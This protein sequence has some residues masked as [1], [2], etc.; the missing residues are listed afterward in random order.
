MLWEKAQWQGG[1]RDMKT[2]KLKDRWLAAFL[3]VIVVMS[4][5]FFASFILTLQA[6]EKDADRNH[7]KSAVFMK[8]MLDESWQRVFDYSWQIINAP[9]AKRMEREDLTELLPL[10]YEFS[11]DF[12]NYIQSNKI[13]ED[14]Y[15]YY[16]ENGIVI[17]NRG[18]YN[19]HV[20]WVTLYGI[21]KRISE[22]SWNAELLENRARGYFTIQ[23]GTQLELYYRMAS[24]KDEGRILIAKI[25][26]EELETTLRW[27]CDDNA[28]SFLAMS[29]EDGKIYAY[30][31]SYERF[32]DAETNTVSS[33]L[34]D[35]YLITEKSSDITKLV[36]LTVTEK[37]QAYR[38]MTVI[39]RIS[40]I[41]LI[42]A[43]TV[44]VLIAVA[45]TSRSVKPVEK[46]VEKLRTD[47]APEGNEISFIEQQI[48]TLLTESRQSV[49][50]LEKQREM[51]VRRTFLSE[52]LKM[53]SV[54]QRDIEVIAGFYGQEFDNERYVIIVRERAGEDYSDKILRY[55]SEFEETPA[56]LCWT[57]QQDLDVFFLNYDLVARNGQD[58]LADFLSDLK[59]RSSPASRI[60]CS[61]SVEY[62]EQI[63]NCYLECLQQ[64]GRVESTLLPGKA[65]L[66]SQEQGFQ[67]G[68]FQ[69]YIYDEDY[70]SARAMVPQ[71]CRLLFEDTPDQTNYIGRK[72]YLLT[73]L[74]IKNDPS[75]MKCSSDFLTRRIQPLWRTGCMRS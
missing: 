59:E 36:Y 10:A 4:T 26:T 57:Q 33:K 38:L 8:K 44:S 30:A 40:L 5:V 53:G 17:G 37:S 45:F 64:L 61:Q 43:I 69:S 34:E 46:I 74:K 23:A 68:A 75:R 15:L 13:V 66:R 65:E 16:P 14:I 22:K 29:D 56:I 2:A 55:L 72:Y 63:R 32:A 52:A 21:N 71:L 19:K 39:M 41:L 67:L 27:I 70:L 48:D 51:M 12:Q 73:W 49:E 62:L 9:S 54:V 60:V 35:A 24:F 47:G 20:Y 31:G 58:D 42:T 50:Q 6:I 3:T 25:N 1:G 28:S 11:R 7:E 18:V